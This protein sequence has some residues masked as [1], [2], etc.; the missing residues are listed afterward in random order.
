[1]TR[2]DSD[3][4]QQGDIEYNFIM[5]LLVHGD[6]PRHATVYLKLGCL[7]SEKLYRRKL[8]KPIIA[9]KNP[10]VLDYMVLGNKT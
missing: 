5:I 8:G 7:S 3:S 2:T 6:K 10:F 4:A 1:M 9:E